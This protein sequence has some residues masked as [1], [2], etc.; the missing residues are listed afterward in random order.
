MTVVASIRVPSGLER[1]IRRNAARSGM[2]VSA[3][4]GLILEHSVSGQCNLAALEDIPE[5][6]DAKLDLRLSEELIANLRDESQRLTVSVSVY[7]RRI[8]CAYY[9]K[10]LVFVERDGHYTLRG[11]P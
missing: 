10:R 11:K 6:L 9:T 2:T 3:I 1:A 7:I 4:A 8:L 5:F